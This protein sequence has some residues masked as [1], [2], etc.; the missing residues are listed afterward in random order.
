VDPGKCIACQQCFKA[1]CPAIM[2]SDEV[3]PKTGKKKSR[4]DPTLCAGCS[5]CSQICPVKAISKKEA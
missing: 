4:I 3:N 1:G 2:V 5:I